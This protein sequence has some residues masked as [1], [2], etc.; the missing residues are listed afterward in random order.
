MDAISTS[1]RV[2]A[3]SQ[4]VTLRS[5]SPPRLKIPQLAHRV[6]KLPL[7]VLRDAHDRLTRGQAVCASASRGSDTLGL[8][9]PFL[10]AGGGTSV[11]ALRRLRGSLSL[12][13]P[14]LQLP[15]HDAF[16]GRREE[17][18]QRSRAEDTVEVDARPDLQ[19]AGERQD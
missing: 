4:L 6:V 8:G 19:R 14:L 18:H 9:R 13:I 5:T 10:A 11:R 3:T 12:A 16:C 17:G 1:S 2:R 7:R 15:L